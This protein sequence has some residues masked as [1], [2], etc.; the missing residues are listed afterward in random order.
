MANTM[1]IAANKH[2]GGVRV[3]TWKLV[4]CS[5]QHVPAPVAYAQKS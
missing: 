3:D 1:N 2:G 4:R 5:Q